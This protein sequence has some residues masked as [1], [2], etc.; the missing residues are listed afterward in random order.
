MNAK[1]FLADV[2]ERT[3]QMTPETLLECIKKNKIQNIKAII[4]MYLGGYAE[5]VYEFY[6]IKK[7]FNCYLIEDACHALGSAY[8]YKKNFYKIGSCIHSDLSTFSFHPLKTITSGEG[9]LVT[10]N[11]INLY[12]KILHFKSH[13]IIKKNHWDYDIEHAGF[14]YRLSDI[15]CA[16]A[17]SQLKK[18]NKFIKFRKNIFNFYKN[19]LAYQKLISF[20]DFKNFNLSSFHLFII[21]I[22]FKKLSVTKDDFFKKILNDKIFLQFHY[23]P[24]FFFKKIAQNK[25]HKKDFPGAMHYY[26]YYVSLPIYFGLSNEKLIYIIKKIKLFIKQYTK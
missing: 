13:G 24:I 12:K 4:T 2:D 21:K 22:N 16:L 11:N 7:K 17:F 23:K 14:N 10:T 3:G 6:K 9:G 5:N 18:I 26:K 1:I 25:Y 8:K 15:N 20:P 19:N